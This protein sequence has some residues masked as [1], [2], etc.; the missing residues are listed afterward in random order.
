MRKLVFIIIRF[1]RSSIT[2]APFFMHISPTTKCNLRCGYCY[3]YD[4]LKEELSFSEFKEI[5]RNAENL[6]IGIISFTGGE[7]LLWKPIY[8]ALNLCNK[9]GIFTQLTTNGTLL[10]KNAI[11]RLGRSGLDVITVSVDGVGKLNY[12]QKTLSRNPKIFQLLKYA[13]RQYKT[14]ISINSVACDQN[15][16]DVKKLTNLANKE[17]VPQSIGILVKQPNQLRGFPAGNLSAGIGLSPLL[18]WIIKVK[19]MGFQILDPTDYFKDYQEFLSGQKRWD[20][21]VAKKRSVQVAAN[22]KIYWCW[23]LNAISPYNFTHL[24]KGSWE[25]YQKELDKVIQ[26]CNIKCYSNC[27]YSSYYYHKNKLKFINDYFIPAVRERLKGQQG[28]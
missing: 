5:V 24:N 26:N 8:K 27:A 2:R 3:Q 9:K 17:R 4:E 1:I 15:I 10:N 21:S 28:K 14:I 22:G 19:E 18:K 6:G 20:C 12:S 7:I 16:E 23:K 13:K 25:R 11:D